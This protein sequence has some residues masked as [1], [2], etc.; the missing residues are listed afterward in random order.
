MKTENKK[1]MFSSLVCRADSFMENVD[2][3]NAYL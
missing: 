1:I 3:V 2:K